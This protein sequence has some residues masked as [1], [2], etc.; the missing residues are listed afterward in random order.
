MVSKINSLLLSL[1]SLGLKAE[2]DQ[3][4]RLAS[5]SN[6]DLPDLSK[7]LEP[8]RRMPYEPDETAWAENAEEFGEDVEEETAQHLLE[9]TVPIAKQLFLNTYGLG[10]AADDFNQIVLSSLIR[11]GI[12]P[13]VS[14][15]WDDI[16]GSGSFGTVFR[17][18]YNGK[19]A[20]VKTS[21]SNN[22]KARD[23]E[24]WKKILSIWDSIPSQFKKH[25]QKV[26]LAY[27][28]MIHLTTGS[29][30]LQVIVSEELR[31]L[32]EGIVRLISGSDMSIEK[33]ED[34]LAEFVTRINNGICKPHKMEPVT[35]DLIRKV[36]RD[37]MAVD[38]ADRNE[39]EIAKRKG[40]ADG[41]N[42]NE[43]T[44]NFGTVRQASPV[45]ISEVVKNYLIT[46][47]P[48]MKEKG[49][50]VF[51]VPDIVCEVFKVALNGAERLPE[52]HNLPTAKTYS[53]PRE[54]SMVYETIRW[55]DD[56]GISWGDLHA[57]NMMLGS[58][59]NIKITDVGN[60]TI[61]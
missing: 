58:D 35:V 23:V 2:R 9:K 12:R 27:S 25:I 34:N 33:I 24:V 43:S 49:A 4:I 56:H 32:P 5:D 60:F 8:V 41:Q 55:L 22:A 59:N 38:L 36:I 39:K 53:A 21:I 42:G 45:L 6:L 17:A 46:L 37:G 57:Y 47:A 1:A 31:E 3:I 26:Y 19:P 61:K 18:V 7:D 30:K 28:E 54:V 48:T 50:V 10:M 16:L 14:N 29:I 52:D 51:G 44:S 11:H 20:V 13:I 15:N 40:K